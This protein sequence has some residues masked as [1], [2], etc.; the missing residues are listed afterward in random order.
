M[1]SFLV[2]PTIALLVC[3]P[4]LFNSCTHDYLPGIEGEG[5]IVEATLYPDDFTGFVNAIAADVYLTQG[6]RQEVVV[7]AQENII[8]NIRLHVNDGIWLIEYH[9]MVRWAQPVKIYITVPDLTKAAISGSGSIIGLTA[10]NNLENLDLVISGSG[11]LDLETE[12]DELN[13]RISGAGDLDLSGTTEYFDILI[14][15]S[16]SIDA[17]DLETREAEIT[18]SGSGNVFL[19][20]EDYL[21]V[22]ISGSGSVFYHGTPEIDS[23]ITGSGTVRRDR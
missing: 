16:G 23:H 9:D 8:D 17:Y 7:Q 4:V 21:K 3:I 10:F 12:S 20:V 18:I 15:G 1:K 2:K 14:S 5:E 22:S 11:D 13:V 6:R 19:D